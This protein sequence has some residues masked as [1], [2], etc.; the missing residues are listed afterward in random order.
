MRELFLP[1]GP[2]PDSIMACYVTGSRE[3]D[4]RMDLDD[5]IAEAQEVT[6]LLCRLCQYCDVMDIV[7]PKDVQ[8]WWDLHHRKDRKS[9]EKRTLRRNP[10]S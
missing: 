9:R 2:V 7:L 5:A 3:G 6:R 1:H 8:R 10:V 4:L